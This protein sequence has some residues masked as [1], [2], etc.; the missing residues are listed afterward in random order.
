MLPHFLHPWSKLIETTRANFEREMDDDLN[1]AGAL[2]HV[3][4][5]IR[6]AN[7]L[8]LTRADGIA[9]AGFIRK[10]DTML[11]VLPT[12]KAELLD[13]DIE[14]LI[15]QRQAA[16]KAKDFK[17][18]DEIRDLLKSRGILLEDTPQGM[19][20]KRAGKQ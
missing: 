1:I 10:I 7:K 4:E 9:A 8:K 5:F 15:E 19:R 18:S 16:R 2:A 12:H 11:G 13:A 17:K 20:W 6:E 3:F 14:S